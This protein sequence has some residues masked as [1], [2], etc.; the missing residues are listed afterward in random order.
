M[1]AAQLFL[2]RMI[3]GGLA[4][5]TSLPLLEHATDTVAVVVPP[6]SLLA[7]AILIHASSLGAQLVARSAW[8]ANLVLG[9]LLTAVGSHTERIQGTVLLI[10]CAGALVLLSDRGLGEARKH[11][12]FNPAAFTTTLTL[13]MVLALADTMT[14]VL[15]GLLSLSQSEGNPIL[16]LSCAAAMTAGFVG[17]YHMKA[18]GLLSNLVLNVLI[19]LLAISGSLGVER[20]V[21]ALFVI[22]AALQLVVPVPMLV[23]VI[24][25]RPL[26]HL[27]PAV[28]RAA[29]NVVVALMT[30]SGLLLAFVR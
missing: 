4:V 30:L 22:T 25:K 8:W 11:T 18:W 14:L 12:G 23:S 7:G 19:A 13:T 6:F 10:G 16:L 9:V 26:W 5:G 28:K 3:A 20:E 27:P 2:L 15:F 17:L 1:T 24:A 21:V 29:L